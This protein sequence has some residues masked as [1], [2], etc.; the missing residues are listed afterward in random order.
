[1]WL[2]GGINPIKANVKNLT[3]LQ[4]DLALKIGKASTMASTTTMMTIV[5][6]AKASAL[7]TISFA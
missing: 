3:I 6:A 5:G 2:I 7:A 1:M 4:I